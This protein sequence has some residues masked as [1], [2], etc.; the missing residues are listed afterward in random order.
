MHRSGSSLLT[1]LLH[2][3][4]VNL[5]KELLPA[6]P[7]NP[8]GFYENAKF[9]Q[10]NEEILLQL[11]TDW[12]EI[13]SKKTLNS[14]HTNRKLIINKIINSIESEF[15]SSPL[16]CVKDPRITLLFPYYYEA[17]SMLNI[18]I[19]IVNCTR[20]KLEIAKSLNKRNK[21]EMS[22]ALALTL[23]YS[24]CVSELKKRYD[25]IDIDYQ[26]TLKNP[27]QVI[28]KIKEYGQLSFHV[29]PE[30]VKDIISRNLYRNKATKGNILLYIIGYLKYYRIKFKKWLQYLL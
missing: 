20:D 17:L 10:L 28:E 21:F 27:V 24:K 26:D 8:K 4:G 7:E 1:G 19:F 23:Y 16:F 11:G 30:V 3:C 14:N 29:R 5:G 2:S 13:A 22:Y 15:G 6:L 25:I 9:Y 12:S 18:E